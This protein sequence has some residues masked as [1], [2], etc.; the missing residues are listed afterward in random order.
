MNSDEPRVQTHQR[1][2]D[3][4]DT[5]PCS[6]TSAAPP[7]AVQPRLGPQHCLDLRLHLLEVLVK[8]VLSWLHPSCKV[9]REQRGGG[10][11]YSGKMS[12]GIFRVFRGRIDFFPKSTNI[13]KKTKWKFSCGIHEAFRVFSGVFRVSRVLSGIFRV[14]QPAHFGV[15]SGGLRRHLPSGREVGAGCDGFMLHR[16]DNKL[17]LIL[18]GPCP[19]LHHP[20]TISQSMISMDAQMQ[21]DRP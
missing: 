10:P 15:F 6:A 1:D 7:P 5:V 11:G 12:G 21:I 13:V 19:H 18:I 17:F 2:P 16:S 4:F 3:Y 20:Q 8:S 14:P 9:G